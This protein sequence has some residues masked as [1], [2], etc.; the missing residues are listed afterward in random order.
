MG[1]GGLGAAQSRYG[2]PCIFVLEIPHWV[3]KALIRK[4]LP[5]PTTEATVTILLYKKYFTNGRV[6]E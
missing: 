1:G 4:D 6:N 5:L 3:Q 2:L